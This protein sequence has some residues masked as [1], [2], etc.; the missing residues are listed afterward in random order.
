MLAQLPTE[1]KISI[2]E[3]V[4]KKSLP[5]VLRT[6]STFREITEP[7]L[8]SVVALSP[9][10]DDAKLHKIGLVIEC[11]RTMVARPSA[12]AAVRR[13]YVGLFLHT[14]QD[15]DIVG[16]VLGVFEDALAKLRNLER[17]ELLYWDDR[18][19]DSPSLPRGSPLRSLRHYYGPPEV[20]DNIQ[21][22]VLVTLRIQS[23]RPKAMEVEGALLAAARS[24]AMTLRA[25]GIG[26]EE[27]DDDEK[28]L[29]LI[30]QI[31]LLFPNIVF[32]SLGSW[33][34][35]DEELIDQ[36]IPSVAMMKNLRLLQLGEGWIMSREREEPYVRR[37]HEGCPQLREISLGDEEWR[38][39]E[40]LRQWA[41]PPSH[42][43]Y[44]PR[45]EEVWA[46]IDRKYLVD[47][48]TDGFEYK[49][50]EYWM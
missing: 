4:D 48:Q 6:N 42:S 17:L 8:Y 40:E 3:H 19:Q 45:T 15:S 50:I 18:Y 32:L 28:W 13:L 23:Y 1:L 35:V 39:S 9:F 12:A 29:E 14:N 22:N 33:Y 27:K 10:S 7:I 34:V 20:I 36:L 31:P 44:D 49:L 16:Q 37:L 26:R 38:Y 21:S 11:F 24:N 41:P 30:P 47:P 5:A 43:E 2:L 25:L 46:K